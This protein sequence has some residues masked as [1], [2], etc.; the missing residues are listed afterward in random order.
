M[1]ASLLNVK[2]ETILVV[3]YKTLQL[4]TSLVRAHQTQIEG[5]SERTADYKQELI[6]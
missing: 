6:L 2:N 3:L 5:S 1:S 4:T